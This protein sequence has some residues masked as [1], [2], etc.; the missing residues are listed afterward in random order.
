MKVLLIL[1]IPI[2]FLWCHTSLNPPHDTQYGTY[3]YKDRGIPLLR[4]FRDN[5]AEI[6][7]YTPST[8]NPLGDSVKLLRGELVPISL[9]VYCN[10]YHFK[11]NS[12]THHLQISKNPLTI[13]TDV[14]GGGLNEEVYFV[15]N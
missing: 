10:F 2:I 14:I 7:L 4:Y 5:K 13:S 11:I 12:S 8:E 9:H 3:F 15:D 1:I 6:Y